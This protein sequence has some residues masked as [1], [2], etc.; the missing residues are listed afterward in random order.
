MKTAA[1][2][3]TALALGSMGPV[4][5]AQEERPPGPPPAERR[6]EPDVS[7]IRLQKAIQELRQRIAELERQIQSQGWQGDDWRPRGEMDFRPGAGPPGPPRGGEFPRPE[8]SPNRP[9]P[10]AEFARPGPAPDEREM[11]RPRFQ[12]LPP[13]S[14]RGEYAERQRGNEDLRRPP[15]D[16]NR[17]QG[18]Y[19]RPLR[20]LNL[21][22]EQMEMLHQRLAETRERGRVLRE[23]ILDARRA[24]QAAANEPQLN[25]EA[26][27][28]RA[29]R[30]A[31]LEAELAVTRGNLIRELR[32]KLPPDRFEQVRRYLKRLQTPW[33]QRELE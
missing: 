30:L 15:F 16:A 26:I 32:E 28:Q 27:Q 19:A 24:L 5:T 22:P 7:E 12:P 17:A 33:F 8:T 25:Q 6:S 2:M 18:D 31:K 10:P 9:S 14:E 1:W 3:V 21:P 23:R 4:L 29:T 11:R 13:P 20:G